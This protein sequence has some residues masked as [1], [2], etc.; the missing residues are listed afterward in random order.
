MKSFTDPQLQRIYSL[1]KSLTQNGAA[2][3]VLD[4]GERV[5]L[6]K[7]ARFIFKELTNDE[8]RILLQFRNE[9]F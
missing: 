1:L 4:Q 8:V 3:S 9:F 5:L 2:I 6:G 7:Y